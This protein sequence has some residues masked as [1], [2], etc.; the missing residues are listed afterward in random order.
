[1]SL[2]RILSALTTFRILLSLGAVSSE[3]LREANRKDN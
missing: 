2:Y 3:W 1:M